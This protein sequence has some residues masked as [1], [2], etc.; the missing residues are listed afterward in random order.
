MLSRVRSMPAAHRDAGYSLIELLVG[1][2]LLMIV[3]GLATV[4]FVT[5][6]TQAGRAADQAADNSDARSALDTIAD[7]LRLADTPTARAG[8]STSRFEVITATRVMFYANV[9][10]TSRSSSFGRT[11]PSLIEL[12]LTDNRIIERVYAPTV[13]YATAPSSATPAPSTTPTPYPSPYDYTGNYAFDYV[14]NNAAKTKPTST[15]VLLQGVNLLPTTPVVFTYCTAA[16]SPA[17]NCT[18]T[19]NPKSVSAVVVNL[20][21]APKNGN[22]AQSLKTVVAITGAVS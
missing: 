13:K 8:D 9:D 4:F 21:V 6:S 15:R 11:P 7:E 2:G 17:V 19:T 3:G 14:G 10:P 1:M 5:S 12:V 22:A 20:P 16:T 18:Q